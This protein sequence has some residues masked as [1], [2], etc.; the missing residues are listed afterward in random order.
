MSVLTDTEGPLRCGTL[1]LLNSYA[2]LATVRYGRAP[3]PKASRRSAWQSRAFLPRRTAIFPHVRCSTEDFH[4]RTK[5]Q[6]QWSSRTK[7]CVLLYIYLHL[8]VNIYKYMP[9]AFKCT[10]ISHFPHC[11]I[12][13]KNNCHDLRSDPRILLRKNN[14]ETLLFQQK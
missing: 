9:V 11:H 2:H 4:F 5:S 13:V 1:P 3:L 10:H 6:R 14:F 7:F 8:T 12:L